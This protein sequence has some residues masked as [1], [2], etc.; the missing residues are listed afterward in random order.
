[1]SLSSS[2]TTVV[3][4]GRLPR[5]CF[6]TAGS[7]VSYRALLA[8]VLR[9]EF[10]RA[11]ADLDF[12][13]L[14]VQCGDDLTWFAEQVDKLD[15]EEKLDIK[16]IDWSPSL[17]DNMLECRGVSGVRA[18]GVVI[19][20]AGAGTIMEAFRYQCPLIVVANP[21]LM[22]NHQQE[23]A[24]ECAA[25]GYAVVGELGHLDKALHDS[26]SL[27]STLNL[28]DL[29]PY[30]DPDL[31]LPETERK[32]ILDRI[33]LTCYYPDE[34]FE[35]FISDGATIRSTDAVKSVDRNDPSL[36]HPA[37]VPGIRG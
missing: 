37:Q 27:I 11:L 12:D 26:R 21:D 6:V 18:P 13:T 3:P 32:D 35:R 1:M 9:P 22:N 17:C 34:S 2:T 14:E 29:P 31:P 30:E 16:A 20:H 19:A 28:A 36:A 25:K 7:V 10:L 4:S 5:R 24:D 8:S 15:I 23:L 33:L